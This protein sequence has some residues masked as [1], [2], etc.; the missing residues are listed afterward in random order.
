M[1]CPT[2]SHTMQNIGCSSTMFQARHFWCPRCGTLKVDNDGIMPDAV[3]APKL[4]GH[5]RKAESYP[6]GD[7]MDWTRV[8]NWYWQA[9]CQCAG[10]KEQHTPDT[11]V[12]R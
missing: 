9:I 7:G 6:V 4:V 1:S 3:E 5:V 12:S 11:E 2:C 8:N 10:R